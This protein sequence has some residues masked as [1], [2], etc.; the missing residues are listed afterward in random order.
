MTR[1]IK[2]KFDA[3]HV[4]AGIKVTTESHWATIYCFSVLTEVHIKKKN[5][6]LLFLTY[7]Q[8]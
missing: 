8:S 1:L 4:T 7:E 6:K 3:Q 5:V 2:G